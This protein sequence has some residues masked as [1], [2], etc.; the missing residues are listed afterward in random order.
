MPKKRANATPEVSRREFLVRAGQVGVTLSV[1]GPS[2]RLLTDIAIPPSAI[3]DAYAAAATTTAQQVA[4]LYSGLHWRLLG[5]FR[6]GRVDADDRRGH[7]R[8]R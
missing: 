6:G 4:S 5:P 7:L 3:P 2:G 8:C 1:L